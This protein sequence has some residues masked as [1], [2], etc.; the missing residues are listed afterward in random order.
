M[1][2]ASAVHGPG[3]AKGRAFTLVTPSDDEAI[4]NIQKLTGYSIPV[5]GGTAPAAEAAAP[6][7]DEEDV[8]RGAAV[9]RGGGRGKSAAKVEKAPARPAAAAF[10]SA[11]GPNRPVAIAS[12]R[13]RRGIIDVDGP[14][15]GLEGP[16][17]RFPVG[18]FRQLKNRLGAA[19]GGQSLD[20]H[21]SGIGA[22]NSLSKPVVP[23]P[24]IAPSR[25]IVT[26]PPA[27]RPPISA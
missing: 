26:A 23:T 5:H 19:E 4:D 13:L 17:A 6:A 14:D 2:T 24:T 1:S 27:I 9:R 12:P 7:R 21:L 18:R 11:T 22:E 20:Q 16:D 25:G 8:E 15:D 10:R 3:G